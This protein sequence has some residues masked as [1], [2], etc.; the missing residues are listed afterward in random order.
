MPKE[1]DF[2]ND[3]HHDCSWNNY[4]MSL[5]YFVSM[6]SKDPSTRVGAVI[7][8]PYKEIRSTGYN[9][10]PRGYEDKAERYMNKE[11]KHMVI[12]HA[13]E[14]AILNCSLMGV[15]TEGCT[16][17]VAWIPCSRCAKMIVQSGINKV[18]YDRNFP[19]NNDL[20]SSWNCSIEITKEL[21]E[22]CNVELIGIDTKIQSIEILYKG[23]KY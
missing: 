12:N 9:G 2:H 11:H 6:K 13:E 16:L 5:S 10:M 17:Y 22:E 23:K 18:V 19:A 3:F 15:S 21:F 20:N 14:N 1:F 4:F 7:V 8:G